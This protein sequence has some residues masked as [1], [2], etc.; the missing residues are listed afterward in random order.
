RVLLLA[1]RLDALR[2]DVPLPARLEAKVFAASGE[3]TAGRKL[4]WQVRRVRAG[5]VRPR[6]AARVPVAWAQTQ[7]VARRAGLPPSWLW[8]IKR[9]RWLRRQLG[10]ADVVVSMDEATDGVLR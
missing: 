4:P 5:E 9:V 1:E 3:A 7:W 10:A 6:E 2:P 8:T